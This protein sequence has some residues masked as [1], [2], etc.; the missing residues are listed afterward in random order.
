MKK[1]FDTHD[2]LSDI[3]SDEN[4]SSLDDTVSYVSLTLEM[5]VKCFLYK[6]EFLLRK[7]M[8]QIMLLYCHNKVNNFIP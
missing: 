5:K 3:F 8:E 4:E 6:R 1:F 2:Y 7:F